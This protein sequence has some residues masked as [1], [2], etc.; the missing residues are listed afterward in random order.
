[1][2]Y[3]SLYQWTTSFHHFVVL[4]FSRLVWLEQKK[5]DTLNVPPSANSLVLY[6]V[7]EAKKSLSYD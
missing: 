3:I 2:K 1:M 4:S 7:N 6:S 5:K